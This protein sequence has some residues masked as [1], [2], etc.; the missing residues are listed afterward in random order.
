MS[1]SLLTV[2]TPASALGVFI[3]VALSAHNVVAQPGLTAPGTGVDDSREIQPGT[4]AGEATG[5]ADD[6][7]GVALHDPR[8]DQGFLVPTAITQPA[9]AFTL[10]DREGIFP[11]IT[12]G[13]SDR[14]QAGVWTTVAPW[15]TLGGE[16]KFRIY[17]RDRV[18]V[19]LT[20][21][22]ARSQA[23]EDT[24]DSAWMGLF[25]VTGT[26]CFDARCATTLTGAFMAG[27]ISIDEE[28]DDNVTTFFAATALSVAVSR[29]IKLL[30]EAQGFLVYESR[31]EDLDELITFMSGLR[32]HS[33]RLAVDLGL[34]GAAEKR[35][36]WIDGSD[37][38]W[39][40]ID[41]VAPNILVPW[42]NVAY[43]WR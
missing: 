14:L 6:R 38:G 20:G 29:H 17:G 22:F 27:G 3:A 2:L 36:S 31:S 30:F 21:H 42:V 10:H 16:V 33:R 24:K 41:G 8:G 43:R 35:E 32:L 25:G 12:Y 39:Y 5:E 40:L 11:G 1:R 18:Y 7:P 13:I 26:R 28:F 19:A 15:L 37:Q 9:G 4:A 23:I 34:M